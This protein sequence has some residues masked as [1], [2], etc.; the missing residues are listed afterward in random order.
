ML[1]SALVAHMRIQEA[2]RL[3]DLIFNERVPIISITRDVRFAPLMS[4][5]PWRPTCSSRR[6]PE[7]V[8]ALPQGAPGQAR[9]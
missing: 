9:W 5:A 3:S 6:R 8:R 4:V 2:N 7:G 1:V